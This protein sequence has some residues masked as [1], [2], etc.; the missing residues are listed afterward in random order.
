MPSRMALYTHAEIITCLQTRTT[1]FLGQQLVLSADD[2]TKGSSVHLLQA[3]DKDV[4]SQSDA[5]FL[6]ALN[7]L[8][9]A[10]LGDPL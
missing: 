5:P 6:C 7:H 8:I 9:M 2:Q 1:N 10:V 3:A 4:D